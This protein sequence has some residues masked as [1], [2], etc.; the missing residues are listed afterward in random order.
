MK[1]LFRELWVYLHNVYLPMGN[2]IR[3]NKKLRFSE[4]GGHRQSVETKKKRNI[5]ILTK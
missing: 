5:F 2:E 1:I 4:E 3:T